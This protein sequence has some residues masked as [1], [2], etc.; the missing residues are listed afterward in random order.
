MQGQ[1]NHS[2]QSRQ[3][4]LSAER[5]LSRFSPA[6]RELIKMWLEEYDI[7]SPSTDHIAFA[8]DWAR[9]VLKREES[10]RPTAVCGT[11]RPLQEVI[12]ELE[13]SSR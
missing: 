6:C 5:F 10:S 8:A 13:N 2:S 3:Y 1:S 4:P 12:D 9:S 7:S 11:S